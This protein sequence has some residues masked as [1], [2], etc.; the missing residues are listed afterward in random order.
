MAL[1]E[2]ARR[3]WDAAAAAAAPRAL[4]QRTLANPSLPI[5]QAVQQAPRILVVGGGKAGA[6]MSAALEEALGD[7][8]GKVEGVVNVP[9]ESVVALK[10]IRLQA[11]RPAATNQPT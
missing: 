6:A 1:R 9:A 11:A 2:D 4:T 3:I 7:E 8:L 10:K 5:F